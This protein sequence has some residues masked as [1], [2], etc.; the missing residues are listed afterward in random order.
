MSLLAFM[1]ISCKALLETIKLL[2]RLEEYVKWKEN[3]SLVN[4]W[5]NDGSNVSTLEKKTLKIYHLLED[6]NYEI[7]R[8][9]ADV[10]KKFRKKVLIGVRR[11]WCI[12]RY[13]TSPD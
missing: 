9:Y 7:L 11:T 10:W 8:I 1:K 4:V 3:M 13:Q 12:N 2:P 5:H 6:L